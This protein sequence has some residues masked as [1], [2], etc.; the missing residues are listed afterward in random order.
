MGDTPVADEAPM[1]AR[2]LRGSRE[3]RRA[4][5]IAAPQW[6][7]QILR[8]FRGFRARIHMREGRARRCGANGC[9]GGKTELHTSRSKPSLPSRFLTNSMKDN[10]KNPL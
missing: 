5:V 6:F 2:V 4:R 8:G 3:G 9:D 1:V 10:N 7:L